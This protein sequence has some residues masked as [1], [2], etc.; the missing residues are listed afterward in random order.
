MIT[1]TRFHD[2]S[3]GHRVYGHEGK[4]AHLHGHSYRIHFT[5]RPLD[6]L[7]DVGRVLDFSV[8]N[9]LLCQWLEDF[10][11]HRFL[12]WANDPI[13]EGLT[14]LDD[15]VVLVPFNPTAENMAE[16]LLRKI[17]PFKLA[18]TGVELCEVR[19]EETRKC[20]ATAQLDG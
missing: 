17:G 3:T 20:L 9:T 4:C 1:A 6:K 2:F 7:D 11:D 16:H 13:A 14:Y 18:G 5:V 8:I 10:W 15:R 12:I 19:V